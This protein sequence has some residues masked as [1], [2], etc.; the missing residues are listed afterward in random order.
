[1]RSSPA[2][3]EAATQICRPET[4]PASSA[5]SFWS[6]GGGAASY[7]RLPT[8]S[9]FAA[10]SSASRSASASLCARQRSTRA[11][12]RGDEVGRAAPAF[13]GARA[14]P[15]VD[16]RQRRAGAA[17]FEDHVRPD[18]GFGDQRQIRPPMGEEAPHEP[19]RVERRE[20]MQ[21]ARR[22]ALRQQPRRG[23]GA[24]GHQREATAAGKSFDQRH[25]RQGLADAGAVQPDQRPLRA[26]EAGD[27]APLLDPHRI[28][29][30][31]VEPERQ[32]RRRSAAKRGG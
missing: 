23:D 22:Q 13:V 27:A 4:R 12:Q 29:L 5:S 15:R 8:T 24:G 28:F 14:H 17:R 31:L 3:V 30:G 20:L 19:R 11:E 1:M 7:F 32:Q 9:T 21:R 6:A 10:P 2:W 16:H 18:L 25:Q 26:G